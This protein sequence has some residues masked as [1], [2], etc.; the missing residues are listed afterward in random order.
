ML[1]E[2]GVIGVKEVVAQIER[3]AVRIELEYE[4]GHEAAAE[5][6]AEAMR[7]E[8]PRGSTDK[9]AEG[10][11]IRKAPNASAGDVIYVGSARDPFSKATT[12]WYA[13]FALRGA[14]SRT[15]PKLY[16]RYGNLKKKTKGPIFWA[17][18][19]HPYSRVSI[20]ARAPDHYVTRGFEKGWPAA[21]ETWKRNVSGRL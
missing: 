4:R 9:L 16:S 2:P 20:P 19:D 15:E 6:L 8:A 3:A 12:P 18:A 17:G 13:I 21:L 11:G 10:I 14:S 5:V 1:V 7:K